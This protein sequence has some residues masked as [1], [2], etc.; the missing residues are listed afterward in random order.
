[1]YYFLIIFEAKLFNEEL[2]DLPV[3]IKIN[4]FKKD[5]SKKLIEFLNEN[6]NNTIICIAIRFELCSSF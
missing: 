1:M 3:E 2:L 4:S 6:E 5:S